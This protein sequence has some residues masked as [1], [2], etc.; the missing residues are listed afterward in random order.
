MKLATLALTAALS[1]CAQMAPATEQVQ[2]CFTAGS[3]LDGMKNDGYEPAFIGVDGQEF[4]T[5]LFRNSDG[6]W[7][8]VILT[9]DGIGCIVGLGYESEVIRGKPNV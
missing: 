9:P 3:L 2:T 5:V 8:A 4:A 6:N 1:T 7:F